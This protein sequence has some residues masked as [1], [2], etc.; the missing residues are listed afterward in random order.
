MN[1]YE[2]CIFVYSNETVVFSFWSGM[3]AL[4][5]ADVLIHDHPLVESWFSLPSAEGSKMIVVGS[6]CYCSIKFD[7]RHKEEQAHLYRLSWYV[8]M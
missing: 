6:T 3:N 5:R 1:R 8:R 2:P 7:H 4:A